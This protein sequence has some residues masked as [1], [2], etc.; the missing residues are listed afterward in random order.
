MF[1]TTTSEPSPTQSSPHR[2]R[3]F[4]AHAPNNM[5]P[6]PLHARQ[7]VIRPPSERLTKGQ[8]I[9]VAVVLG[10]FTVTVPIL[11]FFWLRRRKRRRALEKQRQHRL[12]DMARSSG[13]AA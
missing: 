10:V 3:P 5:S 4:P 8:I 11:A 1:K 9:A 13:Y 6:T 2:L 12:N 7:R